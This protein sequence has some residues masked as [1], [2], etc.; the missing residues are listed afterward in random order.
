[1]EHL[2]LE[3]VQVGHQMVHVEPMVVEHM[4]HVES[5]MVVES[6]MDAVCCVV[7]LVHH[8]V[9]QHVHVRVVHVPVVRHLEQELDR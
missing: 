7:H 1:M 8:L 2:R 9:L 5:L 4:V 3:E 6:L